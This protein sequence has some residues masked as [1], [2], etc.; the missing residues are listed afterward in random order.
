MDQNRE[1]MYRRL[2]GKYLN[3]VFIEKVGEFI[4][5]TCRQEE[6]QR[7]QKLK[8]PCVKCRSK[9][10]SDVDTIKLHLYQR[11]FQPNYY[12]WIHHGEPFPDEEG[13]CASSSNVEVVVNPMREMVM[14]AYTP[15]TSLLLQEATLNTTHEPIPEAKR[16]LHLL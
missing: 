13:A 15:I 2:D 7:C 12:R 1:W 9:P 14:D 11:G 5:F 8:C 16:F 3:K 10:Y 4:S 6:F